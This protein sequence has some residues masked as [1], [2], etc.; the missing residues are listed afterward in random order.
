M[1]VIWY[2]L[3][4]RQAEESI[5]KCLSYGHNNMTTA[6]S[7]RSCSNLRAA[8]TKGRLDTNLFPW[9]SDG[10]P[11]KTIRVKYG[12]GPSCHDRQGRVSLLI[13]VAQPAGCLQEQEDTR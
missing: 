6:G 4:N 7:D 13:G 10:G 12:L 2:Y 5:A 3:L 1:T 11:E 8:D 9:T